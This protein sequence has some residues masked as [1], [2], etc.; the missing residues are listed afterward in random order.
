MFRLYLANVATCHK[1]E[2]EVDFPEAL[3]RALFERIP[4][5]R[6]VE[7]LKEG[8]GTQDRVGK[9]RRFEVVL[10]VKLAFEV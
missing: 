5:G 6:V 4:V 10:D 7:I 3:D 2:A 1:F 9:T 8:H